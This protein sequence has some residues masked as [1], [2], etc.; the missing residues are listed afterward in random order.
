MPPVNK[1]LLCFLLCAPV[2]HAA[3]RPETFTLAES[4][5]AHDTMGS[6]LIAAANSRHVVWSD[7][8]NLLA[9]AAPNF[10]P[11]QITAYTDQFGIQNVSIAPDG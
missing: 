5:A 2:C 11:R 9:A 10:K 7:G 3:S 8:N 1:L 4:I 6:S